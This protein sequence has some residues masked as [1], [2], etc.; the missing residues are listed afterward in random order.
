MSELTQGCIKAIYDGE[1]ESPLLANPIVQ[2]INIKAVAANGGTRY[3][4]IVSD[5]TNFMQA[6]F[7]SQLTTVVDEGTLK[8]NSII[9]LTEFLC[10]ELQNRKILMIMKMVVVTGD[11]PNKIGTP[12]S[13]E[14]H[15]LHN[16]APK[17]TPPST[18]SAP[19]SNTI[20]TINTSTM[21]APV[22]Q[23]A[24]TN[25][26]VNR[27]PASGNAQLEASLTPIK[28]LNP[29]QSRWTIKARVTQKSS[30]KTWTNNRGGGQLFSVN[31][32][33]QTGEI[34]ATA[35]NDQVDRLYN[36]F[37]EGKVY[38]ISKAR[39]TIAKKQFSILNN[40]YEL[41]FE[42][43]TEIE[44]CQ[45]ETSIPQNTYNFVKIADME[46]QQVGT[47]VDIL[48]V[49]VADNGLSEIVSKATG[50][51]INKRDLVIAD[52]SQK[53]IKLTL[54]DQRATDFVSDSNPIIA[55]KG[56][57]VSDFNNRSLSLSSGGTCTLNPNL[58]EAHELRQWYNAH[59]QTA[60][61]ESY[62]GASNTVS[63]D[64]VRTVSKI[65]IQQSKSDNLG[66]SEKPDYFSTRAVISYIKNDPIA[67]AGCPLCRKKVVMDV[68]SWRCEKCQK[69]F[70][71]PD[72]KYMLT[73]GIED[74]TSQLFVNAFDD[75]G[76]TILKKSASELVALKESDATAFQRYLGESTFE[77]YNFKVRAK[78][79]I[80]N[81][82]P[83]VKYQA[84]EASPIDY[85]K[86]SYELIT[87]IDKF[88]A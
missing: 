72:Y 41:A 81:D 26:N 71:H 31:L 73:I 14:A 70:D 50:K 13:I 16:S 77:I 25:N 17:V 6:M 76:L 12:S 86:E 2:V 52:N 10:N 65:T 4:V 8:R 51:P 58:P 80:F 75:I 21:S 69:S 61:F 34:K 57:R 63:G 87:E 37:E 82:A 9:R 62:S 5:G 32:I 22:R 42:S 43:G 54:W 85:V 7:A 29:Y 74:A 38:Y 33:D 67:Y 64:G 53:Q 3:R 83:R 59:G 84:F 44:A 15:L 35:F 18:M 46:K 55:C 39:V 66:S 68:N 36:L 45:G 30:I 40:E 48:A 78:T 20:N 47:N 19:V 60:Q 28:N 49:V 79:E 24:F 27:Y 11:V 88:F 56:V 23:P 1:T